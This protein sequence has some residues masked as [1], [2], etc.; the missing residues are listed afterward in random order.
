MMATDIPTTENQ[1]GAPSRQEP[2]KPGSDNVDWNRTLIPGS[3]YTLLGKQRLPRMSNADIAHMTSQLSIMIRSGVDLVSALE[4]LARQATAEECRE[5]LAAIHEDVLS[6]TPFSVALHRFE[7]IFGASY[8]ASVNAGEASGKMWEVLEHL[9]RLQTNALKLR[10][11]IQTLIAYPIALMT[12]SF[13]VIGALVFGVLPQFAKIF[14]SQGVQLPWLTT[15]L[16]GV[17]EEL[18]GRF[19]IWIPV[20]IL[21]VVCLL[22]F[23]KSESGKA[24]LD[25]ISLNSFLVGDVTRSLLIGRATQLMGLLIESG[26]PL[27][28]SLRLVK[29]SVNNRYFRQIFAEM[30]D[31]VVVGNGLG[32]SLLHSS[33]IPASAAEML[34][35]A[36]RTGSLAKVTSLIGTHYEEQGEEKLRKA[37]AYLEPAIT[38]LMGVIV[39]TI[40]LAVA[41]PMFDLTTIAK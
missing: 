26:V 40:V 9:A 27:L 30:E 10:Q 19:W 28:E 2:A 34:M 31:S 5:V 41:L 23:I 35:T 15:A 7:F 1:T 4:S 38:V 33:H 11:K 37:T 21:T 16:I 13:L 8:V 3:R 20:G 39:A 25:R 17:S 36:E 24:L 32:N 29:E 6:G 22:R 12:V 18:L 14:E